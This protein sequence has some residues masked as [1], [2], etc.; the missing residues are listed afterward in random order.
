ME[1][2]L[3]ETLKGLLQTDSEEALQVEVETALQWKEEHRA[4]L[5][6]SYQKLQADEGRIRALEAALKPEGSQRN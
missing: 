2:K 3:K 6:E 4:L 5:V 1:R